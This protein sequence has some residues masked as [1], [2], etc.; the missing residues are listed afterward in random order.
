MTD[1]CLILTK[2]GSEE[3]AQAIAEALVEHALAA[4]V[5]LQPVRT[6]VRLDGLTRDEEEFQLTVLTTVD[7]QAEAEALLLRLHTYEVPEVLMVR[8]DAS[9]KGTLDWIEAATR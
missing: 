1:T 3:T 6:Y 8:V 7:R 2:C 4:S 5:T 9:A